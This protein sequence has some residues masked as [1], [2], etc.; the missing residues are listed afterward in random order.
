[1]FK[2]MGRRSRQAAPVALF[3]LAAFASAPSLAQDEAGVDDVMMSV[4]GEENAN[5]QAFAEEIGLPEP[6]N[7]GGALPDEAHDDAQFGGFGLDTANDARELR[8]LSGERSGAARELGRDT[9]EVGRGNGGGPS[10]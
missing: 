9:D 2:T 1:M 10:E 4:V 6:D 7:G 3:A 5:E 8:R